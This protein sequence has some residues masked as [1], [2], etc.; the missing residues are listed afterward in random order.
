[1]TATFTLK[2]VQDT[3]LT[4]IKSQHTDL[5]DNQ[6]H[7]VLKGAR[8]P[9]SSHETDAGFFVVTLDGD[10]IDGHSTWFVIVSSDV[11]IEEGWRMRVDSFFHSGIEFVGR[12]LRPAPAA[13]A[14]G[15][16]TRIEKKP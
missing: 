15:H 5:P 14:T 13:A 6:K 16:E 10:Q 4:L 11:Q 9:L 3:W 7:R 1:M 12:L 2:I 8:F